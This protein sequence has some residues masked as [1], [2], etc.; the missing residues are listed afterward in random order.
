MLEDL[1]LQ[2]A[3]LRLNNILQFIIVPGAE[4]RVTGTTVDGEEGVREIKIIDRLE[5]AETPTYLSMVER[6][7]EIQGVNLERLN[8]TPEYLIDA[9]YSVK[10]ISQSAFQQA[11]SIQIAT[12]RE[13][14]EAI[15]AFFP[16]M[17]QSASEIFFKDLIKAYDDDPQKYLD[18]I[19]Q[20]ADANAQ[21][22]LEQGMG[23]QGGQQGGQTSQ[24][25]ITGEFAPA[26]AETLGQLSG[27]EA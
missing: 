4:F 25:G 17:F 5:N 19:K 18:A 9:K 11:K 27:V 15:A 20:N 7:A 23:Q 16:N 8:V 13:K 2:R 21:Q 26:N 14:T 3:K 22:L 10:I 12:A 6:F 24:A 1:V